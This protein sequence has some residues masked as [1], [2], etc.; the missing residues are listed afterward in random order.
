M[1]KSPVEMVVGD[2]LGGRLNV[3][4]EGIG[5]GRRILEFELAFFWRTLPTFIEGGTA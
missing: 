2:I 3:E 5:I 1:A 4:V